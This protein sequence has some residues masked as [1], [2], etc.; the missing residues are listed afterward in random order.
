MASCAFPDLRLYPR[1]GAM[2]L[3]G[4]IGAN[5]TG[6]SSQ[7]S[8]DS[9]GIDDENVFQPRVDFDW[10][11]MHIYAQGYQVEF[12]GEG[13]AES[14]FDFGDGNGITIGDDV[15]TNLDLTVYTGSVVFDILPD[16][17]LDLGPVVVSRRADGGL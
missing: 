10:D 6:V 5:A 15:Q 9:L 4:D 3:D 14:T 11:P 17:L 12:E 8:T 7:A 13:T 1:Y 16:F 2:G